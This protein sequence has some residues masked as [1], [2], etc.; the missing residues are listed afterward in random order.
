MK[1]ELIMCK[2]ADLEICMLCGGCAPKLHCAPIER[3][4]IIPWDDEAEEIPEITEGMIS[5]IHEFNNCGSFTL[6]YKGKA[7]DVKFNHGTI[8]TD[9][10]W[11]EAVRNFWYI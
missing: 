4:D 9:F 5:N 3:R 6:T 10:P 1:G 11:P 7:Y 2:K 8:E